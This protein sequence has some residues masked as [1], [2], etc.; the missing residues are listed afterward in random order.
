MILQSVICSIFKYIFVI[1][2]NKVTWQFRFLKT[3]KHW[4]A[5]FVA[6]TGKISTPSSSS[7]ASTT[8][9]RMSREL[10]YS[11]IWSYF[12]ENEVVSIWRTGI[13]E[14]N[15]DMRI[16]TAET[17]TTI[18]RSVPIRDTIMDSPSMN[19]LHS[20]MMLDIRSSSIGSSKGRGILWVYLVYSI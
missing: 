16:L 19:S 4:I 8:S 1:A 9:R 2:R 6:M 11:K 20:F 10:R 14:N 15:P 3:L 12:S 13:S 5:S 18:S 7:P 17:V